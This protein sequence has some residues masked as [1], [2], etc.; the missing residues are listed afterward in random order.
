MHKNGFFGAFSY[1]LEPKKEYSSKENGSSETKS[2]WQGGDGNII[3][4]GFIFDQGGWGVGPQI[5]VVTA[6][7]KE[8]KSDDVTTELD[9][10]WEEVYTYPYVSL[11][12]YF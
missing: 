8:I 6:S 5:S 1:L 2:T 4:V 3:D 12:F 7:Y 9:G 11:F 10:K